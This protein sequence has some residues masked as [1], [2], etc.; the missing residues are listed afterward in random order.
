MKLSDLAQNP[1]NPRK[2]SKDKLKA[3]ERSLKE[4]GDLGCI[5]FN[6]RTN[7][8]IGGH[9]RQKVM[10]GEL[11]RTGTNEGYVLFNGES[12]KYREVDWDESKEL[13]ANLAAN[14]GAGQWD[15]AQLSEMMQSLSDMN[16][17]LDLTMFDAL[18]R[19]GLLKKPE[20]VGLI[21]DD[22][23]PEV[24]EPRTKLGDIWQLGNHKLVCGD[25][26]SIDVFER[27]MDGQKAD[28]VFT[29]PPYGIGFK[30]NSHKDTTGDEYKDFC[31]DW[32]HCLRLQSD[33]IVISTGWAYN[34]FWYQQEPKDT[35]Y[36][37]CRNKRTGGSVSHFRKVEPL[38]IWGKPENRYDFD[39]FEQTHQI[40]PDLKG[41]HTCPKP[42]SLI[43][44][45]IS[46][47]KNKG[48]V[49]DIFGGSGT[50]LIACEKTGRKCFMM[51]LDPKYCDVITSRWEAFTGKKACLI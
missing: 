37:L 5:V 19:E 27:L 10:D 38:F 47:G 18:E 28:M 20:V 46:G 15:M 45:I 16:F 7:R 42:V 17:D 6:R 4:F 49:L 43:E 22:E 31:R 44:A 30:Y 8:L 13:A 25:S 3:L 11:I 2:A 48:S 32:F 36:W 23:V 9:Q 21:P 33:F 41:Q 50:T 12:F 39:F 35:F 1:K 24:V 51:E 29:D 14:Q 34:L 26:T 40:E